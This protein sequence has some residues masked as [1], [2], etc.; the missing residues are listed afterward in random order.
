MGKCYHKYQEVFKDRDFG[1]ARKG[2]V[3]KAKQKIHS[4]IQAEEQAE[5][6]ID[7]SIDKLD[8]ALDTLGIE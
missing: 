1:N 4:A 8:D 6:S 3:V 5:T 2:A 7:Q